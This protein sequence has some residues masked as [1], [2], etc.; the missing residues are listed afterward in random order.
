M[1]RVEPDIRQII[2][3]FINTELPNNKDIEA[4][5]LCGSQATGKATAIVT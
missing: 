5:I 2:E 4:I 1:I 3:D